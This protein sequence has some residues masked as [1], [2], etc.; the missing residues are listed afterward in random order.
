M[1]FGVNEEIFM[2]LVN[3]EEGGVLRSV[4]NYIGRN[5]DEYGLAKTFYRNG[6]KLLKE[7]GSFVRLGMV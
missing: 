6:V 7:S 5:E 4:T 2:T 3:G 1:M